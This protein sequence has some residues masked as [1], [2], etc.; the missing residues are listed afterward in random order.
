[1]S[2]RKAYLLSD[3]VRHLL[4]KACFDDTAGIWL[5]KKEEKAITKALST[6]V[7][8]AQEFVFA[9]LRLAMKRAERDGV[10]II[11][12]SEGVLAMN[13]ITFAF[14]QIVREMNLI[15]IVINDTVAAEMGITLEGKEAT[16]N[17]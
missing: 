1:M 13:E 10:Y 4:R 9:V 2:D 7:P 12:S 17:E 6:P 8:T 5:T 16:S 15:G 3:E 11:P 14:R